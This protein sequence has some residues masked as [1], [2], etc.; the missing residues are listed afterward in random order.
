MTLRGKARVITNENFKKIL[1]KFINY[2]ITLVG[3]ILFFKYLFVPI[4]PFALALFVTAFTRPF[5]L[6]ISKKTGLPIKLSVILFTLVI[7]SIMFSVIY[8]CLTRL[9]SEIVSFAY[10]VS[11]EEFLNS[12]ESISDKILDTLSGLSKNKVPG[13]QMSLLTEK[14]KS[15]D[16]VVIQGIKQ[17]LPTIFSKIGS[18]LSGFPSAILFFVIL[19]ISLFYVGCDYD[20]INS[21]LSRQLSDKMLKNVKEVKKVFL[22]TT[23]ELFKAYFLITLIT[24]AQLVAGFMVLDVKYAVLL[25]LVVSVVDML[26]VL[27]TGTVLVPWGIW[28]Y[29][30][31]NIPRCIGLLVIYAIITLVRQI[32]E[33]KIVGSAVGLSP[34]V[35]LVSMYVGIKLAGF[36]GLF[37]FPI[38]VIVLKSLNEK[39]IIKIYKNNFDNEQKS[40]EL[41]AKTF[42]S[43]KQIK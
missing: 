21:F 5:V 17:V 14:I 42:K 23:K 40:K 4:L 41:K 2:T 13:R 27:G 3:L 6:Y 25:A 38:G 12:V 11:G 15:L 33:P 18:F 1:I 16:V 36:S 28:C 32:A 7:M 35:T 20:K 43:Y 10:F 29:I 9:L 39:N 22:S 31:G 30:T 19:F 26:P 37:L 24:F 8:I 34:L